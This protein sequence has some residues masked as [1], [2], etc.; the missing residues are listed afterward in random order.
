TDNA[1]IAPWLNFF[2]SVVKEQAFQSNVLIEKEMHEDT[3]SPKQHEVLKYLLTVT[4]A[5]PSEI[6]LKTGVIVPTVRKALERLVETGK[7]KRIGRGRGTR[8]VRLH[9]KHRDVDADV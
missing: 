4:E 9:S 3:M 7:V 6:A 2:L 5:S 1:T 8:Y